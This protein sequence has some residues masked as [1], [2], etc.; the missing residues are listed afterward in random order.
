MKNKMYCVF[1]ED[2]YHNNWFLD[3]YNELSDS[4]DDI[5]SFLDIY[6]VKLDSIEEYPSTFGYA[7]DR[8]VEVE[9]GCVYVRG[10]I[11]DKQYLKERIDNNESNN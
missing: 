10:F 8:E 1:I 9:E 2:E 4:L 5:N 3:F 11:F 7:F 6:N